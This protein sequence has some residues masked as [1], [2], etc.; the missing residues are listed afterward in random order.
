MQFSDVFLLSPED[1]QNK[2]E[3]LTMQ[4]SYLAQQAAKN[5][6]YVSICDPEALYPKTLNVKSEI[7][8]KHEATMTQLRHVKLTIGALRKAMADMTTMTN[9]LARAKEKFEEQ[10]AKASSGAAGHGGLHGRPNLRNMRPDDPEILKSFKT[11]SAKRPL[12]TVAHLT[13]N[14]SSSEPFILRKGRNT[15]AALLKSNASKKFWNNVS[16]AF[17]KNVKRGGQDRITQQP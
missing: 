7:D 9:T 4:D 11:A 12:A 14:L 15:V 5:V 13:E 3:C 6:A 16:E 10:L 1:L 8:D 2:V 17:Q